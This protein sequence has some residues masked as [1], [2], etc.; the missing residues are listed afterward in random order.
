MVCFPIDS[1][2]PAVYGIPV[3]NDKIGAVLGAHCKG[4]TARVEDAEWQPYKP[5]DMPTLQT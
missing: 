3:A 4:G 2:C 5:S 1:F